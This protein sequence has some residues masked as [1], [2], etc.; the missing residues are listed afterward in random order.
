MPRAGVR[1]IGSRREARNCAV[2]PRIEDSVKQR[3]NNPCSTQVGP[4]Q[5]YFAKEALGGNTSTLS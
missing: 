3:R 4:S 5:N 2:H 1:S